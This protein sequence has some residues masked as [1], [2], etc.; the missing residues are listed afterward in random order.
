MR[1]HESAGGERRPGS[2]TRRRIL[3]LSAGVFA[4]GLA[5]CTG[6]QTGGPDATPTDTSTATATDKSVASTPSSRGHEQADDP[7]RELNRTESTSKMTISF[8]VVLEAGQ[9]AHRELRIEE[10][11]ELEITG[12]STARM[13]VFLLSPERAFARYQ[14]GER[15]TPSGALTATD[16]DTIDSTIEVSPGTYFLV[17]DNTAIYGGEPKGA[18]R[19]RFDV[20]V[21][22][23]QRTPTET[24]T[25]SGEN[26]AEIVRGSE[27]PKIRR[28][29][30]N[31]GH[32]FVWDAADGGDDASYTVSVDDE[33]VVSDETTVTVTVE[34]VWADSEDDLSFS[35]VFG[36]SR[37][38]HPDNTAFDERVRNNS[39]TWGM[40]REDYSSAW[41]FQIYLR[42]EDDIYYHNEASQTDF[43]FTIYYENL[44][45]A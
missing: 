40:N 1:H 33:I 35:Y 41:R 4:T 15:P 26:N 21:S 10:P 38:S 17:F 19:S 20:T 27:M 34:E 37:R 22:S 42:N 23:G 36:S 32:T 39:H 2:A 16:T 30:D 25:P 18:L 29:T 11:G 8:E 45:L 44:T 6:G 7:F 14:S 28:V 13:D 24:A 5:G 31:L 3:R 9:Y 12:E 43:K